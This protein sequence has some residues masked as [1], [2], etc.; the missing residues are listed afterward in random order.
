MML[1]LILFTVLL[2][3]YS[4]GANDNFKGVATLFGS[5]TTNY[6]RALIWAMATTLLGSLFALVVAHG[7][8]DAFTGKGLVPDQITREP[9]FLLAVSCGAGLAVLVATWTGMPVSTT[10]ALLGGLLG[11][12][13]V[14]ARGEVR[15]QALLTSFVVPLIGTPLVAM[16]LTLVVYPAFR[17]TRRSFGVTSQSCVCIGESYE[18]VRPLPDGSA[19]LVRTGVVVRAAEMND[20]VERYQGRM[21]GLQAGP[22][23]DALHYL[24][25]GAV[26]F[27]RA[28]NDTPK[29]V[30]LLIAAQAL[31]PNRGIVLVAVVM[32]MG[33]LLNARGV[34]ETMSRRITRM[35]PGQGFTANLVTSTL[36]SLASAFAL[37]VSTTHV[38]CGALFGIGTVNGTAQ[39]RTI[40]TIVSAW[41]MTLPVAA[42]LAAATYVLVR[43]L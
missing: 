5:G 27:A 17:F 26:G 40:V 35:S 29:I 20:C 4:N 16:L 10:L 13:L 7:L 6:S 8:V 28:L 15:V 11:A 12:G 14:A 43:Q 30:A 9:A 33:G 24:S 42:I 34:A 25:A 22:A 1:L 41:I 18:P 38:S 36:V 37:P 23:L 2:V 32:A 19:A 31:A 21:L 3:A 39:R